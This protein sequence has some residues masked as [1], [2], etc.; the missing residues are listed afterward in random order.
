MPLRAEI[1]QQETLEREQIRGGLDK[2][3]KETLKKEKSEY[4]SATVYGSASITTLLPTFIKYLDER[5][6]E[7]IKAIK[8]KGVGSQIALMP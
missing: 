4:A 5:K 1:E 8:T 7:R 6:Q 3:R 2:L